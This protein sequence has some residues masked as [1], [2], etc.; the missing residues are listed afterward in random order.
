MSFSWTQRLKA[1]TEERKTHGSGKGGVHGLAREGAIMEAVP[2]R[3]VKRR[4]I[5]GQRT[6]VKHTR[7]EQNCGQ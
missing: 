3:G 7:S 2:L 5:N 1:K 6:R 4:S